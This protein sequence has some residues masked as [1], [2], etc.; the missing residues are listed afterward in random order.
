M[1]PGLEMRAVYYQRLP[2][3]DNVLSDWGNEK[4]HFLPGR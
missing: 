1:I 4:C 2:R 3:G